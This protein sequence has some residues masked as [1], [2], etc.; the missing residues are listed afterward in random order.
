VIGVIQQSDVVDWNL[1]LN[2]GAS[3]FDLTGPLSGNNSNWGTGGVAF[4]ATATQLLYDFDSPIP[5]DSVVFQSD[6][7]PFSD[8]SQVCFNAL[9]DCTGTG[10]S[11]GEILRI[12]GFSDIQSTAVSGTDVV[13]AAASAASTP[14]PSTLAFLGAGLALL[15][16][17]KPGSKQQR[18]RQSL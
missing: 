6:S 2:D 14:E 17:R 16:L 15:G 8:L 10:H 5:D 9:G 1:L 11:G 12:G 13:G 18:S 3:L 7:G 4:T